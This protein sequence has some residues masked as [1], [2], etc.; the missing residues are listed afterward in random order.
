MNLVRLRGL[1]AEKAKED[2]VLN[3]FLAL[4]KDS[5]VYL[6]GAAMIGLGN[7][8]LLP[9]YTRYLAPAIFG[10]YALV[11]ITILI[12]VAVTQLGLGVAYLKWFAEAKESQRGELL[13]SSLTVGMLAAAVGGALL[14]I[15]V[16]S[17]I[18]ETW[19]Q[20]AERNFAWTLL[21]IVVLENAQG[22][23]LTDLRARRW[24]VAFSIAAALRLF[25]I[26][27]ASL[28]FVAVQNLGIKGVFLG[29]LTGD[30]VTSLILLVFC[31]HHTRPRFSLSLVG[32]MIRYGLP[33]VWSGMMGMMLDATGRYF[34]SHYG[35]LDQ[36]GFYGASIKI[37]NIFQM[38]IIQPFGV[39]WGGLMFQIVKWPNAR[40][41]YSKILMYVFVLSLAAALILTLFTPT[42][43]TIFATATYAPGMAVFPLILLVRAIK[44]ME[45]PTSIG[46]YLE[47]RTKWFVLIYSV[48]LLV[49]LLANYTLTPAYGMFGAAHAWLLGWAVIIGLMALIGH[50]YYPLRYNWKLIVAPL[51]PWACLLL[52]HCSIGSILRTLEW[53]LQILGTLVVI[54]GAGLLLTQDFGV[55]QRQIPKFDRRK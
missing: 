46:I 43:F 11:D 50:R 55:G 30:A 18:G 51:F 2:S 10:V 20:T 35:T 54:V 4:A 38:L 33:L 32:P 16:A 42:L 26:V 8:I 53:P 14:M 1:L 22:L 17:P 27:G 45:Y 47:G 19:L 37:A 41:V 3:A 49:N 7:F 23:L 52:S 31:L 9:L 36:V 29:R 24:A 21:P 5:T 39:A 13:G 6:V 12:V 40:T 28:W 44:I 48:G 25:A 15:G 34:V